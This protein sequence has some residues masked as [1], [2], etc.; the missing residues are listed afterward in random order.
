[1]GG[2]RPLDDSPYR[3][4]IS[5]GWSD[6]TNRPGNKK[7]QSFVIGPRPALEE[8]GWPRRR[9]AALLWYNSNLPARL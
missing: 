6:C 7:G 4:G 9:T 8:P 2:C 5:W 1:M 3:L